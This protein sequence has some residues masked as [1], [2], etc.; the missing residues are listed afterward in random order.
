LAELPDVVN[1]G[2]P[3]AT[4]TSHARPVLGSRTARTQPAAGVKHQRSRVSAPFAGGLAG[5]TA[6]C[7][8]SASKSTWSSRTSTPPVRA[9]TYVVNDSGWS[10]PMTLND[11]ANAARGPSSGVGTATS[12]TSGAAVTS[13]AATSASARAAATAWGALSVAGCGASV[14][15]DRVDVTWTTAPLFTSTDT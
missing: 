7:G 6:H 2:S 15:R 8:L 1:V 9:S 12:R 11:T 5:N 3:V 14:S 10:C 13:P 4:S